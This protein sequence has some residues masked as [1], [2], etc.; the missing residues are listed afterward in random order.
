MSSSSTIVQTMK[1]IIFYNELVVDA[2]EKYHSTKEGFSLLEDDKFISKIRGYVKEAL[3]EKSFDK[4]ERLYYLKLQNEGREFNS[5]LCSCMSEAIDLKASYNSYSATKKVYSLEIEEWIKV[6]SI[7]S[8]TLEDVL[9]DEDFFTSFKNSFYKVTPYTLE[10]INAISKGAELIW[11]IDG[12]DRFHILCSGSSF[13]LPRDTQ[14]S[15]PFRL[16][17]GYA[18]MIDKNGKF[19]LIYTGKSF[20]KVLAFKYHYINLDSFGY[21]EVQKSK[22]ECVKDYK[23]LV[24]EII[25]VSTLETLCKSA[26]KNSLSMGR[27]I[28]VDE[29]RLLRFHTKESENI[30]AKYAQIMMAYSLTPVQD[31]KTLLWGYIDKSVK[32]VIACQFHDWNFFNDGISILEEPNATIV[33]DERGEILF[34]STYEKIIHHKERIFFVKE[35]GKWAVLKDGEIYVAFREIEENVRE[36]LIEAIAEVKSQYLSERY[37]MPLKE[38]VKLFDPFRD[39]RDLVDAGLYGHPVRIKESGKRGYISWEYPSSASLYNLSIELPVD[40]FGY[41]FEALELLRREDVL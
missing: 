22:I 7:E 36:S 13:I 9:D 11:S 12:G 19:G 41:R 20:K 32:E 33:I 15:M 35:Q 37:T 28:S 1:N 30:S 27:F 18:V 25:N 3:R 16:D 14:K 24:C 23:D 38:Y 21:A 4:K 2:I 39:R 8:I 26:L 17:G 29:E 6:L 10:D 40:S 5:E 31:A 34:E